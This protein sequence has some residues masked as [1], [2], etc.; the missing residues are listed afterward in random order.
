MNPPSILL[1]HT[2]LVAVAD[3]SDDN[4]DEAIAIYHMLIDDFVE[5]RCLLVARADHLTAVANPDLFASI[6]TLHVARQHRTAAADLVARTGTGIDEAITL[7]LIHRNR[8]RRIAS[9]DERLAAYDIEIVTAPMPNF[10]AP[11]NVSVSA[12]TKLEPGAS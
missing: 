8:I 10:V 5:Q 3:A 6:D 4:H 11:D 7:V 1:D 9:F 2:F 12:A